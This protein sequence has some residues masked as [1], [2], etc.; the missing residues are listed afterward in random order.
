MLAYALVTGLIF[1]LYFALV[2]VGM[3]LAFGAMRIVNLAHG[4]FIM[5]GAISAFW[6][7]RGV[8]L[9]VPAVIAISFAA[10][11]VLAIPVYYLLIPRLFRPGSRRCC[12]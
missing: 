3:S 10:V 11:F 9:P 6:L 7:V 1:G 5:L 8:G 12:R 2:G 4:D